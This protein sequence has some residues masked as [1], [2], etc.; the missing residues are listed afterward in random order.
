MDLSPSEAARAGERRGGCR[1][2]E[3]TSTAVPIPSSARIFFPK[4]AARAC[5]ASSVTA[6]SIPSP[7]FPPIGAGDE[8][9]WDRRPARTLV[10][11]RRVDRPR[12]GRRVS[13]CRPAAPHR[14][15]RRHRDA[16]RP[17]RGE[18]PV[19]RHG[20]EDGDVLRRSLRAAAEDLPTDQQ[21][22]AGGNMNN[23]GNSAVGRRGCT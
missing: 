7:A 3:T 4:A 16:P 8:S 23:G 9:V 20:V 2:W 12:R 17:L 22:G 15:C 6:V 1:N 21:D 13:V 18:K 19:V 14:S 5:I 11:P 10:V